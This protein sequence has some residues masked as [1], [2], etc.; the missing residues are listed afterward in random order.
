MIITRLTG[1]LTKHLT[2]CI[3]QTV[4]NFCI[5]QID[6]NLCIRQIDYNLHRNAI[7]LCVSGIFP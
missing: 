6:Y 2:K 4:Y 3:R 1:Q 7:K 5:S